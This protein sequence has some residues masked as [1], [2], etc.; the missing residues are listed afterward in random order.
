MSC[1][2][3]CKLCWSL[4]HVNQ[5]KSIS[6]SRRNDWR[7]NLQQTRQTCLSRVK[8]LPDQTAGNWTFSTQYRNMVHVASVWSK[9]SHLPMLFDVWK[10]GGIELV[11]GWYQQ[12]WTAQ[13]CHQTW[14]CYTW[15]HSP[16]CRHFQ[17]YRIPF[18]CTKLLRIVVYFNTFPRNICLICPSLWCRVEWQSVDI[19]PKPLPTD[20]P[21]KWDHVNWGHLI[22]ARVGVSPW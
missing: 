1:T 9:Y 13:H 4:Y 18:T 21:V 15:R 5:N 20:T 3:K 2:L 19:I 12:H 10:T 22:S 6:I 17:T 7:R 8:W 11:R 14:V 16:I